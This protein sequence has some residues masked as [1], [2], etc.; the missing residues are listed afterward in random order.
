MATH[1]RSRQTRAS[2][3]S[4]WQ[5]WSDPSTWHEWNPNVERMEMNGPFANGSTGV[6]HTPAGQHHQI[7]LTN[8]QPGRSFDLET[9]VIPLTEFTFHCEVVPNA[10]GSTVSQSLNVS[11]PLGFVFSP[12]A[13]D[14]IA[15]SFEPLLKGLADK[16]EG[17]TATSS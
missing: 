14:R 2:A 7:R 11:G 3:Q 5:V 4:V 10:G 17:V 1:G 6:M 8:I 16:A 15:A 9:K 12:L 13:G